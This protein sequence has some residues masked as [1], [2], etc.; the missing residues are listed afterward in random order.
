MLNNYKKNIIKYFVVLFCLTTLNLG[1]QDKSSI[2]YNSPEKF[3]IGGI[4]VNGAENLNNNTLI[5]ISGISVGDEIAIPGEKIS[6]AVKKLWQQ[7]LFSDV[8][9]SIDKIVGNIVFLQINLVENARLSKFKFKGNIKKS[10]ITSLKEDIK[11]IRGKTLTQNL[12]N[13]S[14]KFIK[15][16][17]INKGYFNVD[18]SYIL[19]NDTTTKNGKDL[20]FN[21]DKGEKIKIKNIII[22]GRKKILNTNKTILN[23]KDSIYSLSNN[24]IKKSMKETKE[25]NFWRF[26]KVSKFIKS[27]YEDDKK[28]I[29]AKYNEIGYRDAKIIDDTVYKHDNKTVTIEITIDEGEL[30]RFGNI[31]FVGNTIYT[32]KELKDYLNISNGDLFDQSIL[33]S[34][35][36]ASADGTDLSSLYLDDGYLFFNATPFEVSAVNNQIDLEIRIYEGKQA[37]VNKVSIK[38]NTKTNDHVIMRELRTNPGDLFKRSDIMRSQRELAQ[39]QYFNPEKFDVKVD[40]DPAKNEVDITYIVE[41]KSSD[42]IQ[43]QG[44]WGAGR[45]VGSLGLS[46]NNFSTRNFFKKEKWNPLPSGDGQ[47]L[48]LSASSNGIYYQNY[49]ISFTEPWLGGKKPNSL[50]VSLYKSVSSNGQQGDQ[51]QAIEITG[52]TLGLGK[53]LK[54]PDDYFTLFN[55]INFQQYK[56][57]NNSSFFSFSNG[58]SNNINY[59][60]KVGRNSVDQLIFPRSGSNFTLGLKLTPPYSMFD[61]VDDYSKLSDQEK[62]DWIEYYKWNFKSSWFSSFTN[63]LVLNTRVEM[64]LLGAYSNNLGVAPFERFYV[65]GDGMSGMGYQF[66]GRELISLR[67][68]SNNSISPQ[69]GATIYNKYTTELRYAISLNPSS[70]FYALAFLEAGNAWSNFDDYNPFSVKRSAGFGVR[71]MLPMIGMMGLDYGWGL[72]DIAGRPDANGGQFHFSIGQQF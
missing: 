56:L 11:L 39:M 48:S 69:T 33:N 45:V 32:S 10:E 65:G 57:I 60:I 51:R 38:G 36:F 42:Q 43:L 6:S 5:A 12:I 16:F 40:P 14:M 64:G 68:Y 52:L 67:G 55:S 66:D 20:V 54:I 72:D 17:Y 63:K 7:G 9:I 58:F 1:A 49:N 24:D 2:D 22:K 25:K 44:G 70:T 3:E 50:T 4:V 23:K 46:F 30:Y 59:S 13:N 34:R 28:N 21:I 61:G 47:I 53:R 15:D 31:N 37:K 19:I 35:L 27:N 62:Y 8:D 41:E 26:W 29:I 18:V 71:I